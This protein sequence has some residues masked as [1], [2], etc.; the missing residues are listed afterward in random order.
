[1]RIL[2]PDQPVA[3]DR[4]REGKKLAFLSC[5]LRA[6]QQ[7]RRLVKCFKALEVADREVAV[8]VFSDPKRRFYLRLDLDV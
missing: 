6:H 7:N 1:M 5:T 3:T 4:Y 2:D 8:N